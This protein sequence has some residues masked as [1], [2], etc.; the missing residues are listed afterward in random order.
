LGVFRQVKL[1]YDGH[2]RYDFH[3]VDL[4]TRPTVTRPDLVGCGSTIRCV[5]HDGSMVLVYGDG[6]K[7][8]YLVNPKIAGKWMFI[9]LK[10][11]YR[12]WPIPIYLSKLLVVVSPLPLTKGVRSRV[13]TPRLWCFIL[14]EFQIC[15][16]LS[17]LNTHRSQGWNQPIS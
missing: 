17:W 15:D 8:W 1:V 10:C 11:I 3:A 14:N 9:P 4:W 13:C 7:P 5:S 12:Y 2:N 16:S 6:S